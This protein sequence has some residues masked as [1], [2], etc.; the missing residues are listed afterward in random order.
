MFRLAVDGDRSPASFDDTI[1]HGKTQ[2]RSFTYSL[3][4]EVGIEDSLYDPIS[5]TGPAKSC[6]IVVLYRLESPAAKMGPW[7]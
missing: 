2:P 3:C 7:L 6:N 4:S 5:V 1:N